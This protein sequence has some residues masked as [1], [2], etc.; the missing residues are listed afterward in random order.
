MVKV[1]SCSWIP[2]SYGHV[3]QTFKNIDKAGLNLQDRVYGKD[4]SFTISNHLGYPPIKFVQDWSG[5]HYFVVELPEE[6]I[7][8]TAIKF[9]NDTRSVLLEKIIKACHTVSYNQIKSDIVPLDF[10]TIVL[11]GKDMNSITLPKKKVGDLVV[12]YDPKDFY[13]SNTISFVCGTEDESLFRVLLFH[14]YTEVACNFISHTQSKII[15]LYHEATSNIEETEKTKDP[16]KMSDLVVQVE[17]LMRESSESYGK[18]KQAKRNFELK[19]E[20]YTREKF[21]QRE[22]STAKALEIDEAFSKLSCD[23]EYNEVLWS[24]VLIEY[25]RNINSILNTRIISANSGRK[26]GFFG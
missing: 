16:A 5:L 3:Y 8:S 1:L 18:L 7:Q 14:A 9:M 20:E 6:N 12:Y 11:S 21:T 25:L 22:K 24:D 26:K 10:H 15:R 4:A 2:R 13:E 23:I 17:K 19:N